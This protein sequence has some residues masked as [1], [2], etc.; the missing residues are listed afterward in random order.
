MLGDTAVAVNPNDERYQHLIGKTCILPLVDREIPIVADDYVRDGL[1]HR[2]RQDDAR[3]TTPTTSR[4]AC[5][6][7]SRRS[8][9]STTTARSTKTAASYKGMDRYEC[10]K[11]VVAD[12]EARGL[13][14]EDRALQP[15]R[16][17]LLP[18]P[19]RRRAPDLRPVVRQ[20]GA[21]W[22]RKPSASSRTATIKFVPERFTKT[23]LNWM[24]NVHD[25]CISRQLWWGHQIP[26]WYC[27]DCGHITVS[28]EDADR[29]ATRCGSKNITAGRGRAGHLVLLARSGPSRP[30]A[31]RTK[32]PRTL[33]TSVPDLRAGHGL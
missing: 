5:G 11:A 1:R 19:Q 22:P 28:R 23:Y 2:L 29:A 25:W 18:L 3:P 13:P 16:R 31:G 26:A 30:W 15:Q 10:R 20:D 17:H 21:L 4:S 24:E 14:R 32:T 8:A 33:T 6:T 27:A 7:I 9:S 12:L